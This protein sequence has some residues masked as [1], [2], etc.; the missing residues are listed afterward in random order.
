MHSNIGIG[1]YKNILNGYA[2][3]KKNIDIYIIFDGDFSLMAAVSFDII[4]W[5]Q[6]H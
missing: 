3:E 4:Q 5:A 1:K 6:K 2:K